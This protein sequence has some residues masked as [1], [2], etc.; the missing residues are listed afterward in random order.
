MPTR[1]YTTEGI[2]ARRLTALCI[3]AFTREFAAL[4]RYTAVRNPTG[5]PNSMAPA[6]P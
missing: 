2:P 4:E 6:V 1:P 5:T 3:T